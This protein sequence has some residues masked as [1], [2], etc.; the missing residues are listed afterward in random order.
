M[1]GGDRVTRRLGTH[2]G[3]WVT[4]VRTRD[5]LSGM[6]TQAGSREISQTRTGDKL[7]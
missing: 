5:S 6:E 1:P 3:L 2:R 4:R 7:S